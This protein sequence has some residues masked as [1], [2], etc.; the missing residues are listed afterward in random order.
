ML[1]HVH[2]LPSNSCITGDSTT[3]VAREQLCGHVSPET[4][5]HAIM[6]ETFSVRFVPGLYNV[7]RQLRDLTSPSSRQR[8]RPTETRPQLSKSNKY[9]VMTPRWGSI[10]RLTDWLAVSHNVTLTL[11]LDKLVADTGESAGTQSKGNVGSWKPL[12]SNG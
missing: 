4:R 11:R 7:V 3:A 10:P 1:W 6:E 9:L 12:P 2:P 5:G 8:G